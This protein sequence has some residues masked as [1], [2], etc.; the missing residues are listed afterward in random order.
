MERS[1]ANI[2]DVLGE[3]RG[4]VGLGGANKGTLCRAANGQPTL[5]FPRADG[6]EISLH[7][8]VDP[9]AAAA[10]FGDELAA[11]PWKGDELVLAQGFG[12]G[13]HLVTLA[14]R[15]A[16]LPHPPRVWAAELEPDTVRHALAG[17]D[18]G[19]LGGLPGFRL[20]VGEDAQAVLEGIKQGLGELQPSALQV[21][22]YPPCVGLRADAYKDQ[23]RQAA[24]WLEMLRLRREA[25]CEAAA[26]DAAY[27][28]GA[29]MAAPRAGI[30]QA[31]ASAGACSGP[32]ATG[33]LA[34]AA[35]LDRD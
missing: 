32:E 5:R 10:W 33:L 2:D 27:P 24:A 30:A 34:L 19:F 8:Q 15:L 16:T 7:S 9:E 18:L 28:G 20:F 35:I 3:I 13:W 6:A 31:L 23:A 14:R 26:L 12:L 22:P 4:K 29:L 11:K 25:P 1:D 17:M 21:A